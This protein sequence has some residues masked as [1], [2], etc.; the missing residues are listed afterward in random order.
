[1]RE[2]MLLTMAAGIV[3]SSCKKLEFKQQEYSNGKI[4]AAWTEIRKSSANG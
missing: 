3:F 1:M 4:I 2:L